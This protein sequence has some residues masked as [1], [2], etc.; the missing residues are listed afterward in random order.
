MGL[1]IIQF[2]TIATKSW[3]NDTDSFSIAQFSVT[4]FIFKNFPRQSQ[5]RGGRTGI[6]FRN[7]FNVS[8]VDGKGNKSLE[9]SD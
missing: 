2:C 3:L 9:F 5:N 1:Q 4:G 7:S 8:L 6:M